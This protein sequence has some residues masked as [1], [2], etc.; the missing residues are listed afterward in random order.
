MAWLVPKT[1]TRRLEDRTEQNTEA[2]TLKLETLHTG[3][4]CA[5]VLLSPSL[6][7]PKLNRTEQLKKSA[8]WRLVFYCHSRNCLYFEQNNCHQREEKENWTI[9]LPVW[10][11]ALCLFYL[12][13]GQCW[14]MQINWLNVSSNIS[15]SGSHQRKQSWPKS[16]IATNAVSQLVSCSV[17]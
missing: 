14:S 16:I 7:K 13:P 10:I 5:E 12:F 11:M 2:Q 8:L 1:K 4:L 6:T 9:A 17:D 3:I 15:I